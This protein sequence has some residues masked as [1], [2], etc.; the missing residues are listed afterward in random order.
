VIELF[1]DVTEQVLRGDLRV[2]AL[3]LD[4]PQSAQ[5]AGER[6]TAPRARTAFGA[7]FR[8][9]RDRRVGRVINLS[10]GGMFLVAPSNAGAGDEIDVEWALPGDARAVRTRGVIVWTQAVGPEANGLGIRFL[11]VVPSFAPI[12]QSRQA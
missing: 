3:W 10:V 5:G 12:T 4:E 1:I 6:R 11:D 7:T 2:V 9:G 8:I